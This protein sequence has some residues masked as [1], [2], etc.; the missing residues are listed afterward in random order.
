MRLLLIEDDLELGHGLQSA[1]AQSGY[2]A[3][4]VHTGQDALTASAAVAYQGIVLDLGLPDLDG[5]EVLRLLRSRGISA[6]VLILTARDDLQ[7]R[8]LG[9]E[10]VRAFFVA[11]ECFKRGAVVDIYQLR[12][13]SYCVAGYLI[14]RRQHEIDF[15]VSSNSNRI[16]VN[17][18]VLT[19]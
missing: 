10:Y 12:R 9:L 3:D 2:V 4:A 11:L 5:V 17:V 13:N 7:N 6:P 15:L 8:I 14:V 16:H 19:H 1:L 18:R